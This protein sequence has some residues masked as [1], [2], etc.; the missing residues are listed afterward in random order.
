MRKVILEL[1]ACGNVDTKCTGQREWQVRSC[2]AASC[3]WGAGEKCIS[4]GVDEVRAE[5]EVREAVELIEPCKDV[6]S[7]FTTG[8]KGNHWRVL[9]REVTWSDLHLKDHSGCSVEY[10]PQ[11]GKG[12][13]MDY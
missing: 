2:V 10:R 12:N 1:W 4:S 11:E 13:Y 8:D 6:R 3:A 5:H 7:T 9:R